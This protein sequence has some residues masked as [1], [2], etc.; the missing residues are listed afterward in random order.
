MN[1]C[2]VV[3]CGGAAWTKWLGYDLCKECSDAV[4]VWS[5]ATT[6]QEE[7]VDVLAKISENLQIH[8]TRSG[9]IE[10]NR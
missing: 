2:A 1:R 9:P 3:E 6:T 4:S 8:G 10:P 5:T 7:A